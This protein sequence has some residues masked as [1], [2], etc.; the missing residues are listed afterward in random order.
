[1]SDKKKNVELINVNER[2][3]SGVVFN[4]GRIIDRV[5][6]YRNNLIDKFEEQFI[7]IIKKN[8]DFFDKMYDFEC[9]IDDK[10]DVVFNRSAE[11]VEKVRDY[12]SK[13]K[14]SAK[15][16]TKHSYVLE[17]MGYVDDIAEDIDGEFKEFKLEDYNTDEYKGIRRS[18]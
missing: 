17:S 7:E 13:Q 10:V 4:F 9:M 18:R 11:Y 16:E 3:E 2:F 1:M 8:E 6:T 15:K 5:G 14:D 12:I